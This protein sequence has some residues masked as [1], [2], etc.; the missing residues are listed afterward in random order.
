[1]YCLD[2]F[3]TEYTF[4]FVESKKEKENG[5]IVRFMS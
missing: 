1:M 4:K 3:I 5:L 2:F